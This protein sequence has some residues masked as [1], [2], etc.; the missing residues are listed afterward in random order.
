VINYAPI[1]SKWGFGPTSMIPG[2]DGID[3]SVVK[4]PNG[5]AK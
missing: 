4:N 5:C 1:D 2:C 3:H